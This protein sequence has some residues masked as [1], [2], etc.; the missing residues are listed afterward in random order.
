MRIHEDSRAMMVSCLILET[1]RRLPPT[2]D[3]SIT[4]LLEMLPLVLFEQD[5]EITDSL[6][7]SVLASLAEGLYQTVNVQPGTADS[8][9]AVRNYCTTVSILS[10]WRAY[11]STAT[12]A[13]QGD[14]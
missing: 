2:C 11:A 12:S 1:R 14:E 9:V 5:V 10:N 3:H 4:A 7:A 8:T 13:V 6:R